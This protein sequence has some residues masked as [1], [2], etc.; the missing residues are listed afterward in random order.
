MEKYRKQKTHIPGE[1]I[2]DDFGPDFDDSEDE[3]DFDDD[4][5]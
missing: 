2:Y 5:R 1:K 3:P 4:E